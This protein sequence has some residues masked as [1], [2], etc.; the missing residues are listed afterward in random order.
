VECF[1]DETPK[2]EEAYDRDKLNESA[3]LGKYQPLDDLHPET[4]HNDRQSEW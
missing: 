1:A 4:A 3:L 2:K